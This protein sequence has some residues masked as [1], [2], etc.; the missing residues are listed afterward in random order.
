MTKLIVA[1]RNFANVPKDK[2][3][4]N[5]SSVKRSKFYSISESK[6]LFHE[7]QRLR[8]DGIRA[9]WNNMCANIV[10]LQ[11]MKYCRVSDT[12]IINYYY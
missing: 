4:F 8:T 6:D 2:I 5:I 7:T 12:F 1:F 3:L 10:Q 9:T 11:G